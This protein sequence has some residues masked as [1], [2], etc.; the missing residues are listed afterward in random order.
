[1]AK[2]NVPGYVLVSKIGSG[3]FADVYKAHKQVRTSAGFISVFP[4]IIYYRRRPNVFKIIHEIFT[5]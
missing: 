4:F 5:K 3:T 1:M 2:P